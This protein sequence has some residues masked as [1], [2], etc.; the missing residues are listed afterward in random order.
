[1]LS[2]DNLLVIIENSERETSKALGSDQLLER[3]L[4]D[5]KP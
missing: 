5:K 3:N 1:M 4:Y 2:K